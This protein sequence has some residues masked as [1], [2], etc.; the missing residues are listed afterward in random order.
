VPPETGAAPRRLECSPEDLRLVRRHH[1]A[2]YALLVAAPVE[3]FWRG[4]PGGWLQLGGALLFLAG[5]IGYRRAG[6]ALGAQLSPLVAP[7]EP[8]RLVAS[9]AY[10]RI[11]HPMY[12]AELAMAFGAALTLRARVA[13]ALAVVFT[14]V[15][16]H[17]IGREE[18]ALCA[19]IAEYPAYAART[20]RLMPYVY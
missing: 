13:G 20:Y 8:A 15:V 12:L 10:A 4:R 18:R 1:R 2:F 9:G 14:A 11:R 3:W 19:R 16:L 17:R 7:R 5:V 6:W